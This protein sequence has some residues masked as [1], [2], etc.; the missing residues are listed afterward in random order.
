MV[1]V[2]VKWF[3]EPS[4]WSVEDGQI[5][6]RADP[7][8]DF[9]RITGYGHAR[10]NGHIYGE[11]LDSDFDLNVTIKADCTQQYDQA[12]AAVRIDEGNW[13][14]TG[15][16]LFNDRLRFSTVVTIGYSSWMFADL[17]KEF[18]SLNLSLTRRGDSIEISYSTDERQ[19]DLAS[20]VYLQPGA[21]AFA[22]VM[23]AAPEGEGFSSRFSDFELLA[24]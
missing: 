14:K 22:G 11:S 10:D 19:L 17:P 5:V 23:C 24:R 12:G 7:Q 9:W 16:E 13:I 8:T 20:V 2:H 21:F 18:R 3:N 1:G 6:V 15:M 4:K